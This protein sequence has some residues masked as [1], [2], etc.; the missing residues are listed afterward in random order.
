MPYYKATVK[1]VNEQAVKLI[2][3]TNKSQA[4]NHAARQCIT[5]E[6]A[7]PEDLIALTKEGVEVE[8]AGDE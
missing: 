4:I 6:I 3:A 2:D 1:A 5:V 7:S 8:K